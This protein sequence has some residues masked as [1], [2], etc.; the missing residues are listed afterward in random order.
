MAQRTV[1]SP[2]KR[3]VAGSSPA[4]GY[5]AGVAQLVERLRTVFACSP[6]YEMM[7]MAKG[8]VTSELDVVG[9]SPAPPNSG[10]VAQLVERK[11]KARICLFL[12]FF[13]GSGESN[14]SFAF[15]VNQ[16][17]CCLFPAFSI[18]GLDR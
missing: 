6:D 17:R 11:T 4:P 18:G 3:E 12:A 5:R 15:G 16:T 14:G 9:S 2:F 1:T 13:C 8:A 10:R 7:A